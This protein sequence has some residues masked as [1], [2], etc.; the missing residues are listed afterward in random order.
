[1]TVIGLGR[2]WRN[3]LWKLKQLKEDSVCLKQLGCLKFM[4]Y[5]LHR[6]ILQAVLEATM[7][8]LRRTQSLRGLPIL[9]SFNH[10]CMLMQITME[11]EGHSHQ[12]FIP[13]LMYELYSWTCSLVQLV[14]SRHFIYLITLQLSGFRNS[15]S[16]SWTTWYYY[17]PT[18]MVLNVGHCFRYISS[19][20]SRIA[21]A[22][23]I[24]L[25]K[26]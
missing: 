1:M 3:C 19:L 9:G 20:L 4:G 13:W 12:G 6:C 18:E 14:N 5:Q 24:R 21:S 22:L 25:Q 16:R 26:E 11:M 10:H 17:Y 2:T 23:F 7:Q 8:L 15:V